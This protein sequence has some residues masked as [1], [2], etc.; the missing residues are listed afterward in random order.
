LGTIPTLNLGL[1]PVPGAI[2]LAGMAG[3]AGM[4]MPLGMPLGVP[5]PLV[6]NPLIPGAPALPVANLPPHQPLPSD[7]ML[8]VNMFDPVKEKETEPEWYLDIQDDVQEE[9]SKYG[10][11]QKCVV[12][13]NNPS[14]LVYGKHVSHTHKTGSSINT[15]CVR[16]T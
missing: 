7:Y 11:V 2:P 16:V 6:P 3:M 5:R 10:T 14:G 15:E 9:C 13:R 8:L 1:P 12:D 4:G